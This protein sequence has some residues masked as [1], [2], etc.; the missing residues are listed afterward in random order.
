VQ[1][2]EGITSMAVP[3]SALPELLDALCVG[4]GADGVPELAQW[5]LQQL[6]DAEAAQKIGARRSERTDDRCGWMSSS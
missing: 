6:I 4:D 5:A 3:D 2:D 1:H